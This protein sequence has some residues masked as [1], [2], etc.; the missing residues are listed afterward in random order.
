MQIDKKMR[1]TKFSYKNADWEIEDLHLQPV[2]LIVGENATGKSRT[3]AQ[4]DRFVKLLTQQDNSIGKDEW[5]VQFVT[6][7]KESLKYILKTLKTKVFEEYLWLNDKLIIERK[8]G[9]T[10]V[11]IRGNTQQKN[12]IQYSPPPKKLAIYSF[13]DIEKFP[14]SEAILEW[15]ENS[16]GFEF[17]YP[18][19]YDFLKDSLLNSIEDTTESFTGLTK[20]QQSAVVENLNIIGFN[21]KEIVIRKYDQND[22]KYLLIEV[23]QS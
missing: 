13:R 6:K 8:K 4:I 12:W 10:F 23:T 7:N 22:A 20:K 1:L 16:Y 18:S 15:A 9:D 2:N 5:E 14:Y 19:K 11:K 3:L 17:S 21:I